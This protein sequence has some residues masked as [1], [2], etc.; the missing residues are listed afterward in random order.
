MLTRRACLALLPGAA[1]SVCARSAHSAPSRELFSLGRSKNANVI[2]FDVRVGKSGELDASNPLDVYWLML[3]ENG[4]REELTWTERQLAYG[5]SVSAVN[6]RGF[7]LRLTACP[8]RELHVR[9]SNGGYGAEL[10]IARQ[11]ATLHHIFV[12]TT[13]GFVPSVQYVDI[14]G[15]TSEGRTV[16]ERITPKRVSR[17]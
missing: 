4:R 5:Y 17:F 16:S 10:A 3:A 2:R 11:S 14:F 7:T 15:H 12:Q 8:D 6:A 9:E 13:E 1:L